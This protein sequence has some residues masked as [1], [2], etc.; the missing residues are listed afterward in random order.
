MENKI[1]H[2]KVGWHG[3]TGCT[4]DLCGYVDLVGWTKNEQI[5]N[6]LL[7]GGI[8]LPLWLLDTTDFFCVN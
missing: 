2:K 1:T 4:S 3:L 7:S 5:Q 8:K 6:T